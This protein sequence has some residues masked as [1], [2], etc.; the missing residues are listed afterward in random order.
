MPLKPPAF[1]Q[2]TLA[3]GRQHPVWAVAFVAALL[4]PLMFIFARAGIEICGGI[5]SLLFL[6]QSYRTR[7][8]A[9]A[10]DPF[11]QACLLL[12][13][14][15]VLVVV[16]LA[17]SPSADMSA[18]IAWFRYPLLFLA[19][20]YWVLALPAART[21]LAVFIVGLMVP[22]FIDTLWQLMTGI[23]LTGHERIESG[24]LTGPFKN[25]K[26]GL[27]TS[28]IMLPAAAI[29]LAAAIAANARRAQLLTLALVGVMVV[30]VLVAGERSAFI[31]VV[32]ACSAVAAGVMLRDKRLRLP[33]LA[34]GAVLA[35]AVLA[36]YFSNGWVRARTD[37]GF[38]KMRHYAQSDYGQIATKAIHV[39]GAHWVHGVGVNGF[40]GMSGDA[41]DQAALIQGTHPHNVYLEWFS[42]AGVPALVIFMVILGALM[43][44]A[45]QH[46]HRAR[47][48][49]VVLPAAALGILLQ[50]FFPLVGMQSIF[51]NWSAM[52]LWYALAI[53]FAALPP[54]A[55]CR[56]A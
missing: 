4:M 16:P 12:W 20:R 11:T 30:M 39:G 35:A 48:R 28:K 41:K 47:G 54:S 22:V 32:F 24:R 46:F 9:W 49:D 29:C 45:M 25:P 21:T 2:E 26:V 14:W 44:E 55:R 40:R 38:D 37:E 18:A 15:L 1:I 6:W 56:A 36:L 50:H 7:Q 19:L 8:W 5:I 42:E 13:A 27:Y 10:R 34:A 23:S 43:R 33:C 3:H 31:T 51:L 17:V 52:L 53:I